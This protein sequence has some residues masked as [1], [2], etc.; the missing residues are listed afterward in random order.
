M[1][2]GILGLSFLLSVGLL[3]CQSEN[4][5]PSVWMRSPADSVATSPPGL[6]PNP[7]ISPEPS[8]SPSSEV[9]IRVTL[10]PLL[11]P[12][13]EGFSFWDRDSIWGRVFDDL[14]QLVEEATVSVDAQSSTLEFH[15]ETRL[16]QG[17]YT[18]PSVPVGI[19]LLITVLKPG[20][21]SRTRRIVAHGDVYGS[22]PEFS[23]YDFGSDVQGEVYTPTALSDRPEVIQVWPKRNTSEVPL[24]TDFWLR[25]SEAVDP[26]SVERNFGVWTAT[27]E[28]L[29]VDDDVGLSGRRYLKSLQ[30]QRR[31]LPPR[32]AEGF[33]FYGVGEERVYH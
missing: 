12:E 17:K 23:Q 30:I 21:T 9:S 6:V 29:T 3:A 28:F 32:S 31:S 16:S 2:Q 33:S 18:F 13:P 7:E 22:A 10:A 26:K 1:K 5:E 24:D 15:R 4:T 8:S 11:T 19:S 27:D 14:G 20:Y 25:F